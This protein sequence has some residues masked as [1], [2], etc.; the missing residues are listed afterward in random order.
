MYSYLVTDRKGPYVEYHEVR[1]AV[2]GLPDGDGYIRL[3]CEQPVPLTT[4]KQAAWLLSEQF[5][6]DY[7]E[8]I[9]AADLLFAMARRH[10]QHSGGHRQTHPPQR[11]LA[12]HSAYSTEASTN[13]PE[14]RFL[15]ARRYTATV[16]R[17]AVLRGVDLLEGVR[18]TGLEWDGDQVIGVRLADRC[19]HAGTVINTAGAWAGG[20]DSRLTHP[21]YPDHGQIMAV[22][23]PPRGLR[24]NLSRVGAEGYATP[25]RTAA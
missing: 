18:V 9:D 4:T 11:Y 24:H 10:P 19:W 3:P 14:D 6:L 17:A 25:R 5:G 22:Q 8:C 1:P 15:D 21:V 7:R 13:G 16:L 12:T 2:L 23:G 20:I